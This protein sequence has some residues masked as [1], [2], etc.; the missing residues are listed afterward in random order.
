MLRKLLDEISKLTIQARD[1]E[2]GRI[3]DIYFDDHD[4][5]VRYFV[6]NTG[7]WLL[8]RRVLI[9][10]LAVEVPD[11]VNHVLR[12]KLTK[13]QVRGSPDIDLERPVS[14]QQLIDLHQYYGWPTF[15]GN[16]P[17]IGTTML[18]MYPPTLMANLDIAKERA[19]TTDRA[20]QSAEKPANE[21]PADPH[22]RS[23]GEVKGYHLRAK[24]GEFGYVEDFFASESDWVIR[25]VLIDS[26]RW[27]RGRQFLIA[28]S[29]IKSISWPE[30]QVRVNLTTEHIRHSPE[31]IPGK[32]IERDYETELYRHYEV[33][34]YWIGET[35]EVEKTSSA[36]PERGLP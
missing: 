14:R 31:Y 8:G 15:W 5:F 2:A 21:K 19:E 10:P 28:P 13:E 20:A 6:V 34:G 22:L 26:H 30:T 27:L 17:M 18:G 11:W 12:V 24:D 7:S 36:K 29:W 16:D 9:S 4:W 1:E 33:P 35:A 25:Y 32:A 3:E 23:I